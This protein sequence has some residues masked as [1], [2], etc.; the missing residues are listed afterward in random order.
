MHVGISV[1]MNK[2]V[3][4]CE[5]HASPSIPIDLYIKLG[6]ICVEVFVMTVFSALVLIFCLYLIICALQYLVYVFDV[7]KCI[8]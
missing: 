7:E 2:T 5:A 8:S 4:S 6:E 3:T 1:F